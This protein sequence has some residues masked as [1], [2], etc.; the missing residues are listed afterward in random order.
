MNVEEGW[1]SVLQCAMCDLCGIPCRV[2]D[3]V[4]GMESESLRMPHVMLAPASLHGII[5]RPDQHG[6][7][8][9]MPLGAPLHLPLTPRICIQSTLQP[10][11]HSRNQ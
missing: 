7:G 1:Y 10:G 3:W 6:H 9:T 4:R 2:P 11:N 5:A 8:A